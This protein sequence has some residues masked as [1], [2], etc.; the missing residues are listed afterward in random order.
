MVI[1]NNEPFKRGVL[2]VKREKFKYIAVIKHIIGI[3]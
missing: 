2:K 1:E 3:G